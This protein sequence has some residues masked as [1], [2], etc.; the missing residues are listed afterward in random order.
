MQGR[1][2]QPWA[3]WGEGSGSGGPGESHDP[4]MGVLN[5]T[6]PKKP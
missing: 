3:P 4:S 1:E 6:S 2:L 5:V